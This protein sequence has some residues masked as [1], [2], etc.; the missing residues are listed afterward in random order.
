M[1]GVGGGLGARPHTGCLPLGSRTDRT[2]GVGLRAERLR[3]GLCTPATLRSPLAGRPQPWAGGRVRPGAAKGRG[4]AGSQLAV[5]ARPHAGH[6]RR[7][8]QDLPLEFGNGRRTCPQRYWGCS[9]TSAVS[10]TEAAPD[11]EKALK[12]QSMGPAS[13]GSFPSPAR[14][15]LPRRRRVCPGGDP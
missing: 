7:P 3:K 2:S 11:T 4:P 15:H 5:L 10:P 8:P 1:G 13:C 14:T 9:S 6:A 12:T